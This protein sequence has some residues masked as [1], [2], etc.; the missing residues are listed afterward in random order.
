MGTCLLE[1]RAGFSA[2]SF[3]SCVTLNMHLR[4]LSLSFL[5]CEMGQ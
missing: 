2:P 1:L 4:A 5:S 3:A